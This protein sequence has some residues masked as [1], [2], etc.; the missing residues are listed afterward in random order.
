M[1]LSVRVDI[2]WFRTT[3]AW[4]LRQAGWRQEHTRSGASNRR[5]EHYHRLLYEHVATTE[6]KGICYSRMQ[7]RCLVFVDGNVLCTDSTPMLSTHFIPLVPGAVYLEKH[8][9]A[10]GIHSSGT[11]F[12]SKFSLRETSLQREFLRSWSCC[13]SFPR[14]VERNEHVTQ[15]AGDLPIGRASYLNQWLGKS[16]QTGQTC[17]A[18]RVRLHGATEFLATTPTSIFYFF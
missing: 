7:N 6:V 4:H 3:S 17:Q 8:G 12:F 11:Q 15:T 9:V 2:C 5:P 16:K 14:C 18:C 13:Q 10:R 1:M